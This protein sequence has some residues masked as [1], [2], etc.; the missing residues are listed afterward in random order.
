V[1]VKIRAFILWV[2]ML[3]WLPAVAS[4]QSINTVGSGNVAGIV[5]NQ[6]MTV[7]GQEFFQ[8][9]VAAWRDRELAERYNIAIAEKPSARWGSQIWVEFSQRRIFQ[10][11]LPGARGELRALGERAA[12]IVFQRVADTEV[13]RLLFRD[14][15][16]GSDEL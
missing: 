14:P 1:D 6:T 15:D 10:A 16:L 8:Y 4:A 3:A 7:A 13:E 5:I 2:L 12:D 11:Q 9:F